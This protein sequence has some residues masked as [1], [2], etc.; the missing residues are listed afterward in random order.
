MHNN[1]NREM[2]TYAFK[3]QVNVSNVEIFCWNLCIEFKFFN[4]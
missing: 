1:I 2:L 4:F 3:T